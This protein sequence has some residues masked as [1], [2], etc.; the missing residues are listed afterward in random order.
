MVASEIC[1]SLLLQKFSNE[2]ATNDINGSTP[3][4]RAAMLRMRDC[5]R[6][7]RP[8]S[9]NIS[10]YNSD[11]LGRFRKH[12]LDL[13]GYLLSNKENLTNYGKAQHDGLR[14]SSVDLIRWPRK[15][16]PSFT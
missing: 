5:F 14:I 15:T 9:D 8:A 13:R 2:T 16:K 11:R 3:L 1:T 12:L 7:T 10:P 4:W 6:G